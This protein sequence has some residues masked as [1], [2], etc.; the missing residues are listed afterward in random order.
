VSEDSRRL[1]FTANGERARA[2]ARAG[3]E[4]AGAG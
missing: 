2:L 3:V 4:G 1:V